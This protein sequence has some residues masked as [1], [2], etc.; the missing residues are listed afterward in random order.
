MSEKPGWWDTKAHVADYA[1]IIGSWK[2]AAAAY[3]EEHQPK[4]LKYGEGDRH[5]M[6]LFEAGSDQAP[7][8]F[9]IVF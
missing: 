2:P 1:G 5:S 4:V 7:L 8:L 9:I 6:D 3:R